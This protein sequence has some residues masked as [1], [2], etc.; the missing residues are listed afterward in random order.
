MH[1]F[2]EPLSTLAAQT[3]AG[4]CCWRRWWRPRIEVVA[5]RLSASDRHNVSCVKGRKILHGNKKT[6]FPNIVSDNSRS[7]AA[8][9]LC[10]DEVNR[11][12]QDTHRCLV[13]KD[14]TKE[15]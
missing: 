8:V 4:H 11:A 7:S 1:L 14:E 9:L 3:P 2:Y 10:N 13:S 5:V 15:L 6:W 12:A